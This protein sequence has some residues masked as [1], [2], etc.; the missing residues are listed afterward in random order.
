MTPAMEMRLR[1]KTIFEKLLYLLNTTA[2]TLRNN[3]T[4]AIMETSN[5]VT[6]MQ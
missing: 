6:S 2:I 4:E 3:K 5:V 1:E